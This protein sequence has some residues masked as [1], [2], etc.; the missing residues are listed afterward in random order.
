MVGDFAQHFGLGF[1]D[2]PMPDIEFDQSIGTRHQGRRGVHSRPS[3]GLVL[4][5]PN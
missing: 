2:Q 3:D 1:L 4:I 5:T